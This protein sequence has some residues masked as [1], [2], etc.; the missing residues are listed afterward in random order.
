[1]GGIGILEY[2]FPDQERLFTSLLGILGVLYGMTVFT[3]A[4]I[5]VIRFQNDGR[6]AF[7]IPLYPYLLTPYTLSYIA[8]ALNKHF[9]LCP[10]YTKATI[11]AAPL[12]LNVTDYDIA[13][14]K[15]WE[16]IFKHW[17]LVRM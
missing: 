3:L 2:R 8:I 4:T 7:I 6:T 13:I 11:S 17:L 16:L 9:S 5:S 1:M 12:V 15:E 10:T 14:E